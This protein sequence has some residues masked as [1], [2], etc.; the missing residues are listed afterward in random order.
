[1]SILEFCGLILVLS[2][3][4]YGVLLVANVIDEKTEESEEEKPVVF[5][6]PEHDEDRS[7]KI[8]KRKK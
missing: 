4:T 3:F 2:L 7:A 1:M 6:K 5:G 8:N